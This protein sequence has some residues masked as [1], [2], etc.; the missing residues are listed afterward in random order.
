MEKYLVSDKGGRSGKISVQRVSDGLFSRCPTRWLKP[1]DSA[2]AASNQYV[3][4]SNVKAIR[5]DNLDWTEE[6]Q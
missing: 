3:A 6:V 1:D 5:L 2:G 4:A